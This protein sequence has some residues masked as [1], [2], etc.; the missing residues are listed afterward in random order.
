MPRWSVDIIRKRAEHLREVDAPGERTAYARFSA[1][2]ESGLVQTMSRP[3]A[4][5]GITLI[6]LA[7]RL[8]FAEPIN[9]T[10]VRVIDGW[11]MRAESSTRAAL[12]SASKSNTETPQSVRRITVRPI[13]NKIKPGELL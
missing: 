12:E 8:S 10:E 3:L 6:T 7:S 9:P 5:T 1:N 11:L 13:N 4:S 2:D